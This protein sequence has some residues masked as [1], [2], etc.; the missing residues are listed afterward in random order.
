MSSFPPP[1]RPWGPIHTFS[2]NS[3]SGMEIP[4]RKPT[5]YP[6]YTNTSESIEKPLPPTPRKSSSVYSVQSEALLPDPILQ[7]TAYR[8]SDSIVPKAPAIRRPLLYNQESHAL[9]DPIIERR[10]AE[11]E[12]L[13]DLGIHSSQLL[14][15]NPTL[16]FPAH[17]KTQTQ[18]LTEP[19]LHKPDA[20]QYASTYKSILHTRSSIIPNITT[21]TYFNQA[22]LSVPI[23]PRITDVV[24]ESLVPPPLRYNTAIEDGRPS[25][26]F[27]SSSDSS[28]DVYPSSIG[29]SIRAYA[30]KAF[31]LRKPHVAGKRKKAV[32]TTHSLNSTLPS[33]RR[34]GSKIEQRRGSIQNGLSHMY[35]S[36]RKLSIPSSA[37]KATGSAKKRRLPRELRNP[38]IP[39]TPYQQIG[40]KAWEKSNKSRKHSRLESGA[41]TQSLISSRECKTSAKTNNQTENQTPRSAA[42]LNKI[43]T[44]IHN[45]TVQVESAMGLNTKRDKPSKAELRRE[46][47]KKKIVVV[48]LGKEAGWL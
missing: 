48:G 5:P 28:S 38:A 26:Y 19:N 21:E 25:S 22:F 13:A 27:S 6:R 1:R 39:I 17:P 31:Q 3:L 42:V 20:E 32:K 29:E 18:E 12:D 36:L 8:S 14:N 10:R 37:P 40:T 11:R 30:R 44:A 47:L 46:E 7:P 16:D 34:R 15:Q 33:S 45:G 43:T 2:S 41:S 9:S 24:D 4:L 35:T 23:S